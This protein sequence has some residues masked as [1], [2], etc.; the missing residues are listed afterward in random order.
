M[1]PKIQ[2]I[3]YASDLGDETRP[4]SRLAISLA[5]TYGASITMLHALEP[6]GSYGRALIETYVSSEDL[7]AVYADGRK[8]V[9]ETMKARLE[10]F[11]KEELAGSDDL[12]THVSELIVEEGM[13]G[14]VIVR[15]AQQI[16]CDLIVLGTH[17]G[18]S[19]IKRMLIGSTARYVTQHA[20]C[21]VL[22]VPIR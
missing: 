9:L 7:E 2:K 12:A 6:V 1:L 14:E 21:A 5:Q 10:Q 22:V 15:N 3:L 18:M 4:V 17:R 19:G 8:R 16:G 13:P 20:G 11:T